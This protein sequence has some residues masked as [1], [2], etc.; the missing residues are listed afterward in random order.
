ME[1]VPELAREKRM[2]KLSATMVPRGKLSTRNTRGQVY[3]TGFPIAFF[4]NFIDL[5]V[6]NGWNNI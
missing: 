3:I 4:L 1:S 2:V 6:S 5:L